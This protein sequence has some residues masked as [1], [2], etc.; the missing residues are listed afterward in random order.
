MP[1]EETQAG[2]ERANAE[3]DVDSFE[4]LPHRFRQAP[5]AIF[6]KVGRYKTQPCSVLDIGCYRG[7]LLKYFQSHNWSEVF[8]IEPSKSA[9]EF[10]RQ[11]L[12]INV[13]RGYLE[14][15]IASSS[16]RRFGVVVVA[17][18]IE[19]TPNPVNFL[20]GVKE[21]MAPDA[22][23]VLELPY[24]WK[25]REVGHDGHQD[26]EPDVDGHYFFGI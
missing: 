2:Y 4:E 1:Y 6:N 14:D 18:V 10:A 7:F 25:L 12:H 21:I 13:F 26:V 16:P 8:G 20:G 23:L 11:R 5:Q 19:H 22:I 24:F 3:W 17:Q 15:Y 9:S